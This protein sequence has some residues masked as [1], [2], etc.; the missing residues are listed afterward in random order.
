MW[1]FK[2]TL[3]ILIILTNNWKMTE[4]KTEQKPIFVIKRYT[5]EELQS[6]ERTFQFKTIKRPSKSYQTTNDDQRFNFVQKILKK[7]LTIREV[8]DTLY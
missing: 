7:E 2:V 1:Q 5:L 8:N 6:N 4:S 3:L